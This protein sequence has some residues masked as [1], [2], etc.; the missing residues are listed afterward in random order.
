MKEWGKE[1]GKYASFVL[2]R[3]N[4]FSQIRRTDA[5]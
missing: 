4:F 1:R 2:V 3:G 5:K